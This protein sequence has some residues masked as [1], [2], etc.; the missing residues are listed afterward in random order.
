MYFAATDSVGHTSVKLEPGLDAKA[1]I[2]TH[3][4]ALVPHFSDCR[5]HIRKPIIVRVIASRTALVPDRPVPER[6]LRVGEDRV[7]PSVADGARWCIGSH[8]PLTCRPLFRGSSASAWARKV[9]SA[10]L[11]IAPVKVATFPLAGFWGWLVVLLGQLFDQAVT[12]FRHC[13][14]RNDR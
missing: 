3:L 9:R 11:A 12:K 7:R 14:R 5:S 2:L 10:R 1:R 8:A 6:S 4:R 13:F